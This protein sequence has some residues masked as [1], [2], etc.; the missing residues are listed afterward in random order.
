MF[1]HKPFRDAIET[2]YKLGAISSIKE[3]DDAVNDLINCKATTKVPVK[4]SDAPSAADIE[5]DLDEMED[6]DE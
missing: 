3:V 5:N 2:K 4:A 1:K 6:F